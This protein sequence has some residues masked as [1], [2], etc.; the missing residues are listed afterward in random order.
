VAITV[1]AGVLALV[2]FAVVTGIVLREGTTQFDHSMMLWF[3][4]FENPATSFVMRAISF[5]GSMPFVTIVM[6]L[7]AVWAFRQKAGRIGA[8][9]LSVALAAAVLSVLL[10]L[11]FQRPRPDLFLEIVQPAS[12]SF[13]SGHTMGSTA[14]Y[15]LAVFVVAWL[16]PSLRTPLY[17]LTPLLVLLIGISRVFLG[18]HWPTDVLAGFAAGVLM[19]VIGKLALGPVNCPP[20]VQEGLSPHDLEEGQ[21]VTACVAACCQ[22]IHEADQQSHAPV[23]DRTP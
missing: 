2:A 10:K 13:P 21:A 12:F 22:A 4:S 6:A 17:V 3:R 19:V 16:R 20:P 1:G 8:V 7:V 15:G 18:V 23:Q 14:A 5:S 11:V 9:L